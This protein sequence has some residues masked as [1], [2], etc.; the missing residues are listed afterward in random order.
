L[1]CI[2]PELLPKQKVKFD[3][4]STKNV[5]AAAH[6]LSW[7]SDKNIAYFYFFFSPYEHICSDKQPHKL[8]SYQVLT[9]L[10]LMSKSSM[11][12]LCATGPAGSA[13][14]RPAPNFFSQV[15]LNHVMQWRSS[16]W[17]MSPLLKAL[18]LAVGI[19]HQQNTKQDMGIE[20]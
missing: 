2:R 18:T 16:L 17:S 4:W 20:Q 14:T 13:G 8:S 10:P 1:L 7:C 19:R 11:H 12:A 9:H 5:C 15:N 6:R 3:L